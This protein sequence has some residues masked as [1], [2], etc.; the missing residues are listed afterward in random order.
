MLSSP[1]VQVCVWRIW[2]QEKLFWGMTNIYQ[3]AGYLPREQK[4]NQDMALPVFVCKVKMVRSLKYYEILGFP[5]LSNDLK[6]NRTASEGSYECASAGSANC[7][8]LLP[9]P[10]EALPCL[11]LNHLRRRGEWPPL[12]CCSKTSACNRGSF[13]S[14]VKSCWWESET[15]L[16]VNREHSFWSWKCKQKNTCISCVL[17]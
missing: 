7:Q 11:S 3:E 1:D 8:P 13:R 15:H 17:K 10:S 9:S 12:R 16:R 5:F 4:Q 14:H 2:F 6:S